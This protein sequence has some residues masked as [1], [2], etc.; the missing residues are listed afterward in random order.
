MR[1]EE[2]QQDLT[3]LDKTQQDLMRPGETRRDLTRLD[4]TRQDLTPPKRLNLIFATNKEIIPI[5]TQQS[6]SFSSE[7]F[8]SLVV[9][10]RCFELREPQFSSV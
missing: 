5:V 3:R 7:I 10:Q 1:L 8:S 4:E 9:P 6:S 2:T